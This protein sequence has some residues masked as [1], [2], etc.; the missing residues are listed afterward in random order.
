MLNNTI[1]TAIYEVTEFV[2]KA[3]CTAR[4]IQDRHRN[5]LIVAANF[6]NLTTQYR[7]KIYDIN[8]RRISLANMVAMMQDAK[9]SLVHGYLPISLIPPATLKEILNNF[10]FFG[11]N[12]AIPRK[13]IAAYYTFELVRDA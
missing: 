12:E 10:E 9:S 7:R 2:E 5:T 1:N 11:L 8:Q 3:E 4:Y 6:Q 13:I